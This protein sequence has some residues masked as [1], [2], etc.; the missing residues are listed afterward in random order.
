MKI[1]EAKKG[2]R[3]VM[4]PESGFK[5][6]AM[7]HFYPLSGVVGTI[8]SVNKQDT[9]AFVDWGEESGTGINESQGSP[10]HAWHCQV[11]YLDEV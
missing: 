4:T 11:E 1:T 8:L 2:M 7:P 6:E 10:K 9:D 3:V 5:H